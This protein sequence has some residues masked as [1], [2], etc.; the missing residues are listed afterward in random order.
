MKQKSSKT[1]HKGRRTVPFNTSTRVE[2]PKK[3]RKS[4]NRRKDKEDNKDSLDI[5]LEREFGEYI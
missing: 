2:Q 1:P 3:G 5:W 4:Y